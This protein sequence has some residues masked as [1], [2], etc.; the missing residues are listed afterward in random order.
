MS[1]LLPHTNIYR[2]EKVTADSG[3]PMTTVWIPAWLMPG[4]RLR[5]SRPSDMSS[6]TG[7]APRQHSA[8]WSPLSPG[9]ETGCEGR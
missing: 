6:R 2:P 1:R 4:D 7:R 8:G 9:M 5:A 3:T